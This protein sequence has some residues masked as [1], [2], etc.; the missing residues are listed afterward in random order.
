[1][2]RIGSLVTTSIVFSA[3]AARQPVVAP[4]V[5]PA[6]S[7]VVVNTCAVP[8]QE[9]AY[10]I[11]GATLAKPQARLFSAASGALRA[12]GFTIVESDSVAGTL[13]TGPRFTWPMGT[14]E[15]KWHGEANPGV[16]VMVRSV[17]RG[18]DST[19]FQVGARALCLVPEL[20]QSA[21]SAKV[22]K[23]MEMITALKIVNAVRSDLAQP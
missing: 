7:T 17:A 10:T 12:Q 21:P 8:S 2:L 11:I 22:G 23:T 1:M 4:I 6:T 16:Q 9:S 5:S 19:A 18:A 15:E 13:A 3:C 14:E 20:G